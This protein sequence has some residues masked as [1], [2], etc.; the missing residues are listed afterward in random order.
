MSDVLTPELSPADWWQG[1]ADERLLL[2]RCPVCSATWV[3]W[4]PHCPDCGPGTGPRAIES[5]GRGTLYSWVVVQ[6]SVSMPEEPPFTVAS[7]RLDEGAMIYGR[8]TVEPSGNELA[9][10]PVRGSS[11]SAK[12]GR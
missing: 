12:A 5:A 2:L 1:V 4:M 7:V 9:D 10:K 6:H 11:S 8:L 3:P